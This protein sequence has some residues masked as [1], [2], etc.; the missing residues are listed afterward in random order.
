MARGYGGAETA[1][2]RGQST[3]LSIGAAAHRGD[4]GLKP[5]LH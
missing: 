4:V 1:R 3:V 5:D 2:N